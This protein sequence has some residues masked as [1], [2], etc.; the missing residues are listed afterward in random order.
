MGVIY[1]SH[2]LHLLILLITLPLRLHVGDGEVS[3]ELANI[4][5]S[6]DL[7]LNLLL[8]ILKREDVKKIP[9]KKR[10]IVK[11]LVR[12]GQCLRLLSKA[13]YYHLLTTF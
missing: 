8:E 10:D 4:V 11:T 1:T 2:Q 5:E 12:P 3:D 13:S 7:K 9:P 6:P